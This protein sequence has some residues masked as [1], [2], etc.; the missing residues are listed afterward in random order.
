MNTPTDY[1]AY[2][3]QATSAHIQQQAIQQQNATAHQN[4]DLALV[5]HKLTDVDQMVEQMN[6]EVI[7]RDR[8]FYDALESSKWMPIEQL[9]TF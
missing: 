7:D 2:Y 5:E 6:R 1:A 3:Q 8:N 4:E 9:E